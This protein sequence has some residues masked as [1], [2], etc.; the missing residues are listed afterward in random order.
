MR[1]FKRRCSDPDPQLTGLRFDQSDCDDVSS[2]AETI[3]EET[4]SVN[5]SISSETPQSIRKGISSWG[6]RVG[7]RLDQLRSS[8][9]GDRVQ[10]SVNPALD[11]TDG[12]GWDEDGKGEAGGT[13]LRRVS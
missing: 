10:Y 12:G 5:G 13:D 11:D 3:R 6:K 9:G 2:I 8:E 4:T 7:R 1:L